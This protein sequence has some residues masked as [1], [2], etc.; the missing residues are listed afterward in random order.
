[1]ERRD[2]QRFISFM[3]HEE[4]GGFVPV[5]MFS[6]TDESSIPGL[7]LDISSGGCRLLISKSCE[8]LPDRIRLKMLAPDQTVEAEA[9]VEARECWNDSTYSIEHR[10]V[11]LEFL[12]QPGRD[13]AV[14]HLIDRFI[15]HQKNRQHV[16]CLLNPAA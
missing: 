4:D 15:E 9:V 8:K 14:K 5:Y 3:L 7:I 12:V 16:R 1:M 11:G 10:A 6:S 2:N 13:A